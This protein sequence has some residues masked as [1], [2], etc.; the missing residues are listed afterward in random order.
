MLPTQVG[1]YEVHATALAV[2]HGP[3]QEVRSA[4][5]PVTLAASTTVTQIGSGGAVRFQLEQNHPNPAGPLTH[6][7]FAIPRA[8]RTSLRIY[9]ARGAEVE[10]LLD[11]ELTAGSYRVSWDATRLPSGTYFYRLR[12]GEFSIT[13]KLAVVR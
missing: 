1:T 13:R 6:F 11:R 3:P 7:E 9:D 10:S 5:V 2:D 4:V 12:A 8:A